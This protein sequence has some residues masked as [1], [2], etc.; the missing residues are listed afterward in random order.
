[1]IG[2]RPVSGYHLIFFGLQRCFFFLE[3][4]SHFLHR[5]L[6]FT[7]LSSDFPW[8]HIFASPLY[9]LLNQYN[10]YHADR[11]QQDIHDV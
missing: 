2:K 8:R 11:Q 5:K 9:I 3:T 6:P 10:L 4:A 7:G 1:M